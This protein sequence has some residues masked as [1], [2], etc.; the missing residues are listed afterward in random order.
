MTVNATNI[1]PAAVTTEAELS[2]A[3]G[4]Q[5]VRGDHV[6]SNKQIAAGGPTTS[7]ASTRIYN[8]DGYAEATSGLIDRAL[9]ITGTPQSPML[10]RPGPPTP[11]C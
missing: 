4:F 5:S 3:S 10:R 6:L 8:Q 1:A 7:Y 9:T 11:S 2:N